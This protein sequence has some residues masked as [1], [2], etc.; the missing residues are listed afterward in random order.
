MSLFSDY[1][2]RSY[3][4]YRR[5]LHLFDDP[6]RLELE[7]S[8]GDVRPAFAWQLGDLGQWDWD[9]G[10]AIVELRKLWA[11][12][13]V[14]RITRY[15]PLLLVDPKG[16]G[17]RLEAAAGGRI[18]RIHLTEVLITGLPR[19]GEDWLRLTRL[20]LRRLLFYDRWRVWEAE[21]RRTP[22]RKEEREHRAA[23]AE[24]CRQAQRDWVTRLGRPATAAFLEDGWRR[25]ELLFSEVLQG[26]RQ[27]Q[28][29]QLLVAPPQADREGE[30]RLALLTGPKGHPQLRLAEE[31]RD[32]DYV[33]SLLRYWFLRRYDLDGTNCVLACLCRAE[34][35]L[36]RQERRQAEERHGQAGAR[37]L[38]WQAA[39]KIKHGLVDSMR[40]LLLPGHIAWQLASR[41]MGILV[42][43]MLGAGL[44]GGL[45]S[46][47]LS[48]GWEPV[49]SLAW[50]AA[51]YLVVGFLGS[52]AL[53]GLLLV[54]QFLSWG[55]RALYPHVPRLAA[56]TIVGLA[57]LL[58]ISGFGSLG[59]QPGLQGNAVRI[60]LLVGASLLLTVFYLQ[61]EVGTPH[62]RLRHHLTRSAAMLWLGLAQAGA[63]ASLFSWLLT[64]P[65][66]ADA[67]DVLPAVLAVPL[68]PPLTG[69]G[70]A[71]F[72]PLVAVLLAFASL[73]IG[74]LM[75]IIWQ[76]QPMTDVEV[77]V[78]R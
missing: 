45:D 5:R 53:W 48:A 28:A 44:L 51:P 14:R 40:L 52:I 58:N 60:L 65:V 33:D 46:A 21:R 31:Q 50:M 19:D 77:A 34:V 1:G 18:V 17:G 76:E 68:G 20:L 32:L 41:L 75:Q 49:V 24:R 61:W 64:K 55:A 47:R 2:Q 11:N 35:D 69:W 62:L 8:I 4:E 15:L 37:Q 70:V 7:S 30:V 26:V 23:A 12:A 36:R 13:E 59:L 27:K 71:D 67:C 43:V 74:V 72:Y 56:A 57:A 39:T 73:A 9:P 78:G 63:V 25:Y 29:S 6:W 42:W 22:G 66:L 16:F 38:R 3:E 10:P 54:A